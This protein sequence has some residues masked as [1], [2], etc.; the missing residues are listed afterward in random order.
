MGSHLQRRAGEARDGPRRKG[1]RLHFLV[2]YRGT[3]PMVLST[4]DVGL[5]CP[6]CL[7][8]NLRRLNV[9]RRI[10]EL[11]EQRA[12]VHSRQT[13]PNNNNKTIHK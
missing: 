5:P 7:A 1:E 6:S 11:L 4:T 2:F 3:T 13:A 8:S 10:S 9:I 12:A